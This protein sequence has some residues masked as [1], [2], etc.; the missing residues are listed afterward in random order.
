MAPVSPVTTAA[1]SAGVRVTRARTIPEATPGTPGTLAEATAAA[2][3]ETAAPVVR[4]VPVEEQVGVEVPEEAA[5]E[6]EAELEVAGRAVVARVLPVEEQVGVGVPEVEAVELVL[7]V[8]AAAAQ[9]VEVVAQRGV[10]KAAIRSATT[11][12]T[13]YSRACGVNS[14]RLYE[15]DRPGLGRA[16]LGSGAPHR[17]SCADIQSPSPCFRRSDPPIARSACLLR[18]RGQ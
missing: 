16:A 9:E 14:G 4:V 13:G 15:F 10:D 7:E 2:Q 1:E 17:G 8:P 5:Q 18:G 11:R 6:V 12:A 3:A